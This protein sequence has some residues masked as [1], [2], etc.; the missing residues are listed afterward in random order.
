MLKSNKTTWRK[1]NFVHSLGCVGNPD[2]KFCKFRCKAPSFIFFDLDV[3][4]AWPNWIFFYSSRPSVIKII[5][6]IFCRSFRLL[7][8]NC[9]ALT[10][11]TACIQFSISRA[12][13]IMEFTVYG[14][15]FI[16]RQ[17]SGR[18]WPSSVVQITS[19]FFSNVRDFRDILAT[20]SLHFS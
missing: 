14:G 17:T 12:V 13:F 8:L 19:I 11:V 9:V 5:S 18:V 7:W 3:K 10:V 1:L 15:N 4:T 2:R 16:L 6:T 20:F